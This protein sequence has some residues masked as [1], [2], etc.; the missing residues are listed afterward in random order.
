MQPS[1]AAPPLTQHNTAASLVTAPVSS[2]CPTCWAD[3]MQGQLYLL[4]TGRGCW[5]QHTRTHTLVRN[6]QHSGLSFVTKQGAASEQAPTATTRCMLGEA[7]LRH[8]WRQKH[9]HRRGVCMH[10]LDQASPAG[11]TRQ[12]PC[13]VSNKTID[14]QC[15][16]CPTHQWWAFPALKSQAGNPLTKTPECQHR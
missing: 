5:T 7:R 15:C 11:K 12:T 14:K 10:C 1:I 4:C 8:V 13:C 3:A 16:A 9:R 6:S 2:S